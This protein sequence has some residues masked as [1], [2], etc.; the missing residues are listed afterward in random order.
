MN[1]NTKTLW[2]A[3]RE[4]EPYYNTDVDVEALFGDNKE[5]ALRCREFIN[6]EFHSGHKER[7]FNIPFLDEY[8]ESG[9]HLHTVSLYFQGGILEN[10]FAERIYEGVKKY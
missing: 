8:N 4:V 10:T 7:V 6:R 2:K 9:K 3:Y 5:A 1:E